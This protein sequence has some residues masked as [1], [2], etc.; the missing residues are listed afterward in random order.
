MKKSLHLL[1][2]LGQ[3]QTHADV[4]TKTDADARYRLISESYTKTQTDTALELKANVLDVYAKTNTY[5]KSEVDA[6]IPVATDSTNYYTKTQTNDLINEAIPDGN[7]Q[8]LSFLLN[9]TNRKGWIFSH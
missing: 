8:P 2:Q 5:S 7:F 3:R 4:Y 1:H 9:F 6:K